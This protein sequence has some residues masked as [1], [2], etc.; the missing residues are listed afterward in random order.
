MERSAWTDERLDGSFSEL[1]RE[2]A[3][4]RTEM[5]GEFADV[6]SEMRSG[7]AEVRAEVRDVRSELA[8]MKLFM[9]GGLVTILAAII[10]L[11]G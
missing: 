5:R 2:L 8:T 3:D 10:G 9:L 1:R 7:F 11:H 4:M 6:R